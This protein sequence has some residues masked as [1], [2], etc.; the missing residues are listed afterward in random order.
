MKLVSVRTLQEYYFMFTIIKVVLCHEQCYLK[1]DTGKILE[2]S[3]VLCSP[4]VPTYSLK[5]S[6]YSM[7][8][9]NLDES[10]QEKRRRG[11]EASEKT[12]IKLLEKC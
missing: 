3:Y 4:T 12:K 2:Y 6:T 11:R 1:K 7:E 8:T 5:D 10:L 9:V